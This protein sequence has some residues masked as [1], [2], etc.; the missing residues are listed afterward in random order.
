MILD[1][2]FSNSTLLYILVPFCISIALYFLTKNNSQEGHLR[3]YFNHLRYA[4]IVFLATSAVLM[5]G[6]LCVLMFMPIY[7]FFVTLGYFFGWLFS[8]GKKKDN[9]IGVYV[10]PLLVMV[11]V[12]EGL[13]PLTTLPRDNT[14]TYQ[15]TTS[16]S[17]A[18]LKQNMANPIV[19]PANRNG[20]FSLFPLP[21]KVQAGTLELND[22]HNLHFTYKKWG[23]GNFDTGEMDIL[24]ARNDPLH[25]ETKILKN[26]AYLSHYMEI[27]GTDVRFLPLK[28]G[29]TQITL[30]VKYKRLLDPAWY[31]GPM[32]KTAAKQSAKY[33]VENIIVRDAKTE[34]FGG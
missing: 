29:D 12:S 8:S 3:Q 31:F 34:M 24:I 4:T 6:F 1:S 25:I 20:F 22:V 16:Q 13:L 15:T 26:T 14:A 9:E 33:L 27:E 32:Q 7:Y 21:D 18:A 17:V 11:L 19:F 28:N 10:L 23:W 30:T 2:D 5:E